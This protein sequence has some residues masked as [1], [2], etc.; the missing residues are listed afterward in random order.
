IFDDSLSAVDSET[1]AQ[2]RQALRKR[3]KNTTTIIISHRIT[4]LSEA[5]NILVLDKGQIIESGS[6]E[7]LI[8]R[9]GLYRRI[10]EIQSA[11][12]ENLGE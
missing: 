12:G 7:E 6:H 4:T 5:D 2:I 8:A 9:E 11:I 1:D 10:W 3:R